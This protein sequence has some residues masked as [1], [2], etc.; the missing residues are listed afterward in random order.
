MGGGQSRETVKKTIEMEI[1]TE[2]VNETT[3]I[4]NII[5]QTITTTTMNVTNNIA[6]EITQAVGGTNVITALGLIADG[7]DSVIDINQS[8]SVKSVQD[9]VMKISQDSGAQTELAN[10]LAQCKHHYKQRLI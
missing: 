3:N 2:I 4:N 7:A 9:A 10:K 1:Q 6:N 8:I 5:A